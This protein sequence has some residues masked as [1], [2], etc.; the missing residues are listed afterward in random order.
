MLRD[1]LPSV[2]SVGDNQD[3]PTLDLLL[4]EN[5]NEILSYA[6]LYRE[7]VVEQTR[8]MRSNKPVWSHH[9]HNQYAKR[10]WCWRS[11]SCIWQAGGWEK[12]QVIFWLFKSIG[13]THQSV[14]RC[15]TPV[16]PQSNSH[17]LK[18]VVYN[19]M[20][21]HQ[22]SLVWETSILGITKLLC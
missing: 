16:L 14:S 22:P 13:F 6:L 4:S 5:K 20:T 18:C 19:F 10:Q 3:V 15:C 12:Q 7:E 11:H 9:H 8:G 1:F 2:W 21:D 17:G